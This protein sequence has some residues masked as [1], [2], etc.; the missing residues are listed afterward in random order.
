MSKAID[1]LNLVESIC[2]HCGTA[3]RED[4]TPAVMQGAKFYP[5]PSDDDED[6]VT[7]GHFS[8]DQFP[9]RSPSQLKRSI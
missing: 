2:P 9:L 6:E 8:S 1:L 3:F 4:N 7:S 5:L